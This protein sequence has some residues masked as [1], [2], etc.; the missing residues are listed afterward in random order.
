MPDK[1]T[2]PDDYKNLIDLL[3]VFSE[4]RQ[5]L[6][7]LELEAQSEFT[8]IVD[9]HRAEYAELQSKIS[10]AEAAIDEIATRH[11]E[12][13]TEKRHVKTPYGTVKVTRTTK[14]KVSNEE[15]AILRIEHAGHGEKFIRTEKALNLEALEALSDD[16]LKAF[17]II[18]IRDENVSVK[19]ATIDFGK[20]VKAAE[21][22]EA[23]PDAKAA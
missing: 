20:A 2:Q 23:R 15:A 18:R 17:G 6:A 21:K 3:A 12:W 5:R 9:T 10:Q 14:L 13:F 1:N 19:E 22:Q 11:P 7:T 8:E 4:G 16:E